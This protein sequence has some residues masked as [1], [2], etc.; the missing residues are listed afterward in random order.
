MSIIHTNSVC[1]YEGGHARLEPLTLLGWNPQRCILTPLWKTAR[2]P[3]R[4]TAIN[5][6]SF[7][8]SPVNIRIYILLSL[9]AS[10]ITSTSRNSIFF[11]QWSGFPSSH[12]H[13]GYNLKSWYR[14]DRYEVLCLITICRLWVKPQCFS[15]KLTVPEFTYFFFFP[16]FFGFRTLGGKQRNESKLIESIERNFNHHMVYTQGWG[17]NQDSHMEPHS[18]NLY[19]PKLTE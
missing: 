8:S 19:R 4:E 16:F 6:E 14:I 13:R 11:D 5:K 17:T 1:F 3:S 12:L 2:S 15:Q 10:Q 9:T 7:R 18:I